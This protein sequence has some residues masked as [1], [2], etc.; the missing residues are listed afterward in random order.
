VSQISA[1]VQSVWYDSSYV[2]VNHTDV[3]SHPTGRNDNNNPAYA[4]NQNRTTRIPRSPVEAATKTN[5]SLGSIGVMVNGA[6]IFNASDAQS[7]NNQGLWY[8]NANVAEA[9]SFDVGPGHAAPGQGAQ[10]S[11]STPGQYHYHQGPTALIQQVDP[12]NTG[13]HHSPIIG[14]A[15]D[16][17]PIYGPYGYV[18]PAD[19]NSG[20]KRI[21]TSY[22]VRTDIVSSGQ[23]HSLTNGGATLSPTQYGP[24]VSATY[25]AGLYLQDYEYAAGIGDLNQ[26]N[27][28]FTVTPDYPQGT[29]AYFVTTDAT[30]AATYPY[31][32]GPQYFGVVDTTNVGPTGGHATIPGTAL[33]LYAGDA[34]ANG[35]VDVPDLGALASNWQQYATWSGGDFDRNGLVDVADLGLLAGNWQVGVTGPAAT[36]LA[37]ALTSLGLP[38]S[39]PEPAL[40]FLLPVVLLRRKARRRYLMYSASAGST[41][42]NSS[43]T[44][45]PKTSAPT[46]VR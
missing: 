14:F 30:G 22:R 9:I 40:G 15:Y 16:G 24:N 11:A 12:N 3:P 32:V 25:P 26:Y 2:Y 45:L 33:R 46:G 20:I 31:I 19:F 17:Y 42:F 7:Y 1:D 10:P 4:S 27:M 28:R 35:S 44:I 39:V 23:R 36:S 13:Q 29:W 6:L 21:T 18:D 38:T 37:D 8:R 5:T 43:A 41:F 34:D